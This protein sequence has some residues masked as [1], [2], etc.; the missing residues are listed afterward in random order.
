M[1]TEAA[2]AIG[3]GQGNPRYDAVCKRLLS[4]KAFLARIMQGCLEEYAGVGLDEVEGCIEGEPTVGE[5][6]VRPDGG[7]LVR[8]RDTADKAAHEGQVAFDV[9]FDAQVPGSGDRLGLIIN[10]EAQNSFNPGYPLIKRGEYYCARLLSAQGG[11]EAAGGHYERLRKVYSVWVCTAPPKGLAGTITLYEVKERLLTGAPRPE[12]RGN[13]DL[14]TVVRVC[15]G[16]PADRGGGGLLGMLATL[17]SKTLTAAEKK[18][19]LAEGYGIPM[20]GDIE[21]GLDEMC[22]LSL[23]I[24]NEALAEGRAEGVILGRAEGASE[25][26][27]A[28][29]ARLLA[30]GLS[31]ESVAEGT[32]LPLEEVVRLKEGGGRPTL[33]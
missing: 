21:R 13:Y 2:M 31:P 17:F 33:Q 8:G 25:R 6:P 14:Q 15:L 27:A 32:E 24:R 18:R 19:V 11:R 1:D 3:A 28:I 16:G 29:A 22:D 9:L 4:V 7:P 12:P 20:T 10:I 23:G 26:A 5:A 30:M